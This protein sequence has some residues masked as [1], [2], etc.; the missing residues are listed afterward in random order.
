MLRGSLVWDLYTP[1]GP[2][3][4]MQGRCTLLGK[5]APDQEM[6]PWSHC[7]KQERVSHTWHLALETSRNSNRDVSHRRILGVLY[8]QS[9]KKSRYA[10]RFAITHTKEV[11]W[12]TK[13]FEVGSDG[14]QKY[15]WD[16]SPKKTGKILSLL[17]EIQKIIS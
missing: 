4:H 3:Q 14:P 2:W 11:I 17:W 13:A 9:Q 6:W 16:A 7:G 12:V 1:A 10:P 5:E 15:F 8:G